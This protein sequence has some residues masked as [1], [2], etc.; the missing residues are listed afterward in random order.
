MISIAPYSAPE[1]CKVYTPKPLAEA[2]VDAVGVEGNLTW[3]EP[4]FGH[5]IFLEGTR[6]PGEYRRRI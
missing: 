5:G 4:S 1:R 2:M 3:L 6:A